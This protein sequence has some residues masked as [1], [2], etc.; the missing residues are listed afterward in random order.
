MDTFVELAAAEQRQVTCPGCGAA[1]A[2]EQSP[3]GEP[4]LRYR[5]NAMV[6]RASRNGVLNHVIATEAL[7]DHAGSREAYIA[8]G[9]ELILANG[10][11][12]EADLL[13]LM[14]KEV[15]YGEAK[16]SEEGFTEEQIERDVQIAQ[17]VG[18]SWYLAVCP[19]GLS[20]EGEQRIFASATARGLRAAVLT[21]PDAVV[22]PVISTSA[23]AEA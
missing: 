21:A 11:R 5:L 14:G 9:M 23:P 17:G 1:A 22:R 15:W 10:R 19:S 2:F 8:P 6:D 4:L 13:A 16:S 7:T 20:S 18:A 12:A 3:S